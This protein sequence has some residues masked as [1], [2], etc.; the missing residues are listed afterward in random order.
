MSSQSL[1]N[2]HFFVTVGGLICHGT[3]VKMGGQLWESVLTSYVGPRNQTQ[4]LT[5]HTFGLKDWCRSQGHCSVS[6]QLPNMCE[7][8]CSTISFQAPQMP[9][10]RERLSYSCNAHNCK[11]L[12]A[13]ALATV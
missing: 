8:V 10:R 11:A 6:M 2:L 7:T 1:L 3:Y 4:T 13:P 12:G 9:R 5:C